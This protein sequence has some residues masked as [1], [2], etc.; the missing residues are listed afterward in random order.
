MYDLSGNYGTF[1]NVSILGKDNSLAGKTVQSLMNEVKSRDKGI[2]RRTELSD[3][4]KSLFPDE[5][6]AAK[7]SW[8]SKTITL[9]MKMDFPTNKIFSE[10]GIFQCSY[11]SLTTLFDVMCKS[12]NDGGMLT[13]KNNNGEIDVGSVDVISRSEDSGSTVVV[14]VNYLTISCSEENLKL[15]IV[16][17]IK[18]YLTAVSNGGTSYLNYT[19]R[20]VHFAK[21]GN[22]VVVDLLEDRLSF[23][24]D[25]TMKE[26]KARVKEVDDRA[27]YLTIEKLDQL[28]PLKGG[29]FTLEVKPLNDNPFK[30]DMSFPK[31]LR[32]LFN[33]YVHG[34]TTTIN[35]SQKSG[36]IS[37]WAPLAI[38]KS[39][40]D[41]IE[42]NPG[43]PNKNEGAFNGCLTANFQVDDWIKNG[44][45]QT[46][47]EAC[48]QLFP[49][50]LDKNMQLFFK[51]RTSASS[52]T[53][54]FDSL[55]LAQL[56]NT[57]YH[58]DGKLYPKKEL[59]L[60]LKSYRFF[61]RKYLM[62]KTLV[63]K[64][65]TFCMN[66]RPEELKN[67]LREFDDYNNESE[68]SLKTGKHRKLDTEIQ[69]T[70][71]DF[72]FN[73]FFIELPIDE[74]LDPNG[75]QKF[76]VG[77]RAF[78]TNGQKYLSELEKNK[79]KSTKINNFEAEVELKKA[80]L[81][82]K[83]V[84]KKINNLT[85]KFIKEFDDKYVGIVRLLLRE[86]DDFNS[87]IDLYNRNIEIV[88]S[89]WYEVVVASKATIYEQ[90]GNIVN[91]VYATFKSLFSIDTSNNDILKS[92]ITLSAHEYFIKALEICINTMIKNNMYIS[93]DNGDIIRP[94]QFLSYLR[95]S[96][97]FIS[98][99]GLKID[100]LG[101]A[102]M[103]YELKEYYRI[104]RNCKDLIL[105][106]KALLNS[107]LDITSSIANLD[108]V[109]RN[110]LID[111]LNIAFTR[112]NAT[113]KTILE[114]V[115]KSSGIDVLVAV[116]INELIPQPTIN[117]YKDL[118][119]YFNEGKWLK[120]F[121]SIDFKNITTKLAALEKSSDNI[122]SVNKTFRADLVLEPQVDD[123]DETIKVS[124]K[125]ETNK[126]S[127]IKTIKKR[128]KVVKGLSK[129]GKHGTFSNGKNSI[130][131]SNSSIEAQN[132]VNNLKLNPLQTNNIQ[133]N[134]RQVA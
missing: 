58:K 124:G 3:K 55:S 120:I 87:D 54:N 69:G 128:E 64:A 94:S 80:K 72:S 98:F 48:P 109:Y 113:I 121:N 91:T 133:N 92:A 77:L 122:V 102:D 18:N 108:E 130:I 103:M 16:G 9:N 37:I 66:G 111:T 43:L 19:L 70:F 125:L 81:L 129:I 50:L 134:N 93:V 32:K 107:L 96:E 22:K 59:S 88:L 68:M 75:F 82:E 33:K 123:I 127:T 84:L 126:F 115:L 57:I 46:I 31:L 110:S 116:N 132:I 4:Q 27:V 65:D 36:E 26:Y 45:P 90:N 101:I 23:N 89:T 61:Y 53:Y 6:R 15:E 106:T 71:K 44:M 24:V 8:F 20:E 85:S 78:V 76:L 11:K 51:S 47:F 21:N 1:G 39:G 60:R 35:L 73:D 112:Q 100:E 67:L 117:V 63:L 52:P 17:N 99:I 29:L 5:T 13:L 49:L 28:T 10:D 86:A 119:R 131:G 42:A 104:N 74:K 114:V 41:Q 105:I 25:G 83:E 79:L 34:V 2:N 12:I 14:P 56:L 95:T 40:M 118:A 62:Y 30:P 7:T 97:G 38:T